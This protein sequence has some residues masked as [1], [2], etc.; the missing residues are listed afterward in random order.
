[1]RTMTRKQGFMS[2]ELVKKIIEDIRQFPETLKELVPSAWGETTLYKDWVQ[3]LELVSLRLPRTGIVFPTNGTLLG[4]GKVDLLC[5][6]P[7]LRL[8]NLSVN[9]YL[10]STYEYFHKLSADNLKVIENVAARI[11][12]LRPDVRL[13]VSMVNDPSIQS[14]R[15]VDLFKEHW[16]K[17]GGVQISTPSY[18]NRPDRA[19]KIPVTIPCRSIF[20]DIVVSWTGVVSSCCF[21]ANIEIP[22]GGANKKSLLDIW[23]GREF[24][25]LRERHN[26]GNRAYIALCKSCTFS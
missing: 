1:M 10:P 23:H 15:E 20:S 25:E 6:I 19:P 7:T 2:I 5:R 8:V 16:S 26:S 14:P 13:W 24:V 11:R 18:N 17:Y 22:L 21:D 4:D 9:A 3:V 12:E